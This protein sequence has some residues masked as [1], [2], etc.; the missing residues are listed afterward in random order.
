MPRESAVSE[1][2]RDLEMITIKHGEDAM[3]QNV[4]VIDGK[5]Q[6]MIPLGPRIVLANTYPEA[7][8][9][10]R[11]HIRRLD[12]FILKVV[13]SEPF[14]NGLRI[15]HLREDYKTDDV[16]LRASLRSYSESP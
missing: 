7:E 6:G 13:H 1:W 10:L 3:P 4:F 16:Y 15:D 9:I 11:S 8:R 2:K 12:G 5:F 14:T